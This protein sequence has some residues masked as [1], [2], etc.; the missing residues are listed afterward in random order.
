MAQESTV[1]VDFSPA[2]NNAP[3]NAQANSLGVRPAPANMRDANEFSRALRHTRLVTGLRT[4]LPLCALATIGLFFS[5]IFTN[6]LPVANVKVDSAGIQ[7]GKLVMENPTMAGFDSKSRP[8]DVRA[9]QAIQDV[10]QPGKV[11][12][13]NIDAK[14]PV[15]ASSFAN[16]LANSGIYDTNSEKLFLDKNVTITGA[17]GMDM[18]L[19]DADIDIKSGTMA[20]KNPVKANSNDT[21]ISADSV[22]VE[23][24]G[25][26]ILFNKRV[27]MTIINP[28]ERG[29]DASSNQKLRQP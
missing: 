4:I 2:R 26:R 29:I 5:L 12:L 23:E 25:N 8:Y 28:T 16:V 24:G 11:L 1:S 15:D 21:N 6:E 10:A 22:R 27:K 14:L 19:K 3:S 18:L 7:E 9:V 13:N 17:R 20:S